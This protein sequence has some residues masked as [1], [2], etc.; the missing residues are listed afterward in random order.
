MVFEVARPVSQ[1]HDD[2][3]VIKLTEA[4]YKI[5]MVLV[6]VIIGK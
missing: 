4:N 2:P 5:D 6:D 3:I 1:P